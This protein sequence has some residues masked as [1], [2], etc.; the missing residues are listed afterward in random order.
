MTPIEQ[1]FAAF[2]GP[3]KI[4]RATGL[5]VQTVH[6]WSR[7]KKQAGG[8]SSPPNIPSWRREKVLEAARREGVELSTDALT[9]LQSS[10]RAVAA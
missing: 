4:A 2:G 5:S 8:S 7:P 1:I 3:T 10:E 9:Y 6:D